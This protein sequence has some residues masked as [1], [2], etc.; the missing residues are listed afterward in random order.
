MNTW[1]EMRKSICRFTLLHR[2]AFLTSNPV[3]KM[4]VNRNLFLSEV[5]TENAHLWV[6]C[7][8]VLPVSDFL[9]PFPVLEVMGCLKQLC[10]FWG[11]CSDRE[12]PTKSKWRDKFYA[13]KLEIVFLHVIKWNKGH[14][15]TSSSSGRKRQRVWNGPAKFG[16][17]A[18]RLVHGLGGSQCGKP[19][20][21]QEA[22]EDEILL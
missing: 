4:T 6:L 20:R 15:S 7:W 21:D 19:S 3:L 17:W 18:S 9:A 11:E 16:T 1:L 13:S 12:F 22:R 2:A 14:C 10:V 8:K 5:E